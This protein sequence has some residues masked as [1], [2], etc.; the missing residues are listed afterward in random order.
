MVR[1]NW[2]VLV[3]TLHK[4]KVTK[5]ENIRTAESKHNKHLSCPA[6]DAVELCELGDYRFVRQGG[7][8]LGVYAVPNIGI[9]AYVF[10]LWS[11]QSA[12]FQ[13]LLA[14]F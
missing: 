13:F 10:G 8:M 14:Y 11:G 6:A 3:D 2:V 5:R 1:L 12:T 9:V 7:K 4:T